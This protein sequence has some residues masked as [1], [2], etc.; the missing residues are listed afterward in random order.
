[1]FLRESKQKRAGG[2]VVTH[3]QFA[4]SIWNRATQRA[5]THI[6]YNF[7]RA[8]DPQVR[9][10]LRALARS[11][12]RRVAPEEILE[13]RPDWKLLDAWPYGDLYVLEQLWQR[14]GCRSG[15]RP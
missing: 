1:M 14:I 13:A 4:E 12:L 10:R 11:I 7:G 8:D 6:V 2:E 3:L 5:D 9:E 15:S